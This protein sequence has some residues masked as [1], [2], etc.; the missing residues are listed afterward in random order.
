MCVTPW[1]NPALPRA[2]CRSRGLFCGVLLVA[3]MLFP[4][5]TPAATPPGCSAQVSRDFSAGFDMADFSLV[6]VSVDAGALTLQTGAQAINPQRIVIPFEQ[7]VSACFLYENAGYTSTLGWMLARDA[8]FDSA[9]RL[10]WARIPASAKREIFRTVADGSNGGDGILDSVAGLNEAQLR[11]AG[12]LV[13]GNGVVTPADMCKPLLPPGEK[14]AAGEELVFWLANN[15]GRWNQ[16]D[17]NGSI[18]F[19]KTAWNPDTFTSCLGPNGTTHQRSY[20]FG[21]AQTAAQEAGG[22]T[23]LTKGL[24]EANT[25]TRL[26]GLGLSFRPPP[27]DVKNL[28]VTYGQRFDHAIAATPQEDPNQWVLAWED[29]NGGG[30]MDYN[31]ILFRIRR[32]TGGAVQLAGSAA[33]VP[34]DPGAYYTA[35]T[36][37][38]YDEIPAAGSCAGKATIEYHVSPDNGVT[39]VEI[40]NWDAIKSFSLAADGTKTLGSEV[41]GWTPG[42]PER[43]Y[44]EARID[45][46]GQNLSGRQLLWKANLKSNAEACVPRILGASLSGS[47]NSNAILSRSSPI[48][49]GNV[50]Y[51]SSFET[52]AAAWPDQRLRGRVKATRLYD[53]LNPAVGNVLALWD[54]GERLNTVAPLSRTI[55]YPEITVTAV[56]NEALTLARPDNVQITAGD[57]TTSSF[58]GRLAQT[59]ALATTVRI[60]AG[61]CTL[62][63]EGTDLLRGACGSGTINRFTGEFRVIFDAPPP[64]GVPFAASYSRYVATSALRPFI[65]ANVSNGMLALDDSVIVPT[66]Y[67]YDFDRDGLP[68]SLDNSAT[69][70]DRAWLVNWV[71][72]C[73]NWS[74][75][76]CTPKSWRLGAIDHSVPAVLTPP[77]TPEWYFGADVTTAERTGYN[78]FKGNL[79]TRPTVLFV[80]SRDGMVHAFDAGKFRWG[81]NPDT[82]TIKE[83]RGYFLWEGTPKVPNYG[84]GGELWAFIPASLL[85]R[86]KNNR[87]MV[88]DQ[89]FVDASAAL[90]D[91]RFDR[92]G[93]LAADCAARGGS[94]EGALCK[95]V[96]STL[97]L[98]AQGNGGDSIFCL[99][100][101]DPLTP[102]FLW[103]FADPEL[104]RSR[105]SPAVG[106]IGRIRVDGVPRWASFFASGKTYN[107]GLYPSIYVIDVANGS[108]ID[109]IFL[110][111]DPAGIG[112]VPSGQPALVDSDGNGYVDRIYV[113]TDKGR[114]YK[115][116]LSDKPDAFWATR[117]VVVI[118]GDFVDED[119]DL[120]DQGNR[121]QTEVPV[122]QRWHP[123]YASPTVVVDNIYDVS[124]AISYRIRIFFGTGDSPYFDEDINTA[125]T[126]YHFFAYVDEAPKLSQDPG[127]AAD[128]GQ[129]KLDWFYALPAGQ[130][131]FASAFASAGKVYFGT[132]TSDTEDPCGGPNSGQTYVFDTTG[133][134]AMQPTT[135]I[136]S[137]DVTSTP[138]V[139]DRHLFVRTQSGMVMMGGGNF[140]NESRAAGVGQSQ[141]RAWREL[142]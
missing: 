42:N 44:R 60:S 123:I 117:S 35:A 57:G 132:A 53:P 54:A 103:E 87:L 97:L 4:Q 125:N 64:A 6:N 102:R 78:T 75:P 9:G 70:G 19:T 77:G 118:N 113:G 12:Y 34:T 30:D 55:Y 66:G 112:G 16:T 89:A 135:I 8:V 98:M 25:I 50:L 7:E 119:G 109:R 111:S 63:D 107:S 136:N 106:Q 40:R 43:T 138:L 33:L 26:A 15:N 82:P 24:F 27:N 141:P 36:F 137:G 59:P 41:A 62:H 105:S 128:P 80:G 88:D 140:N 31:D 94:L 133:A 51:S 81:D 96:W 61:P 67:R 127:L 101:T 48:M 32:Q 37:A 104:F 110:D 83:N 108:V 120:D 58:R 121:V 18:L 84:S 129:V 20:Q 2:G 3:A 134:G 124:G 22:C 122:A 90:A 85:P 92:T 71:R 29:L 142:D 45:F 69:N 14:F 115:V 5:E 56:T 21:A 79:Q 38:V 39:W 116:N 1:R 126:T 23:T 46:A 68:P 13:D 10:D 49:V 86:L 65:A 28:S 93:L 72:G 76:T 91:V 100:V 74:S 73:D 114:L 47:T 130:R 99:D 139:S 17:F 11:A 95:N 52:P 131:V